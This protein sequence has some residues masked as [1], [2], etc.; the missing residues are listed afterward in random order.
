M[1]FKL[2]LKNI[3]NHA[4]PIWESQQNHENHRITFEKLKKL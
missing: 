1:N 4:I 2:K 3:E